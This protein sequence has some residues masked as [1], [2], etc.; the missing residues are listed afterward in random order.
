MSGIVGERHSQKSPSS[1]FP[2]LLCSR[3]TLHEDTLKK[4]S[5][6]TW[7][8]EVLDS[9]K[10]CLSFPRSGFS[11]HEVFAR[12]NTSKS[13]FLDSYEF[14]RMVLAQFPEFVPHQLQ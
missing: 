12:L 10:D 2:T 9:I 4:R 13:G 6:V 11:I 14:D 7:Q 3:V 8:N 5:Q 1:T